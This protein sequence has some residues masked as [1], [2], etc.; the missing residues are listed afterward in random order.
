MHTTLQKILVHSLSLSNTYTKTNKFNQ[1]WY[2]IV[3][4]KLPTLSDLA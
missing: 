4:V 2:W 3:L 1:I